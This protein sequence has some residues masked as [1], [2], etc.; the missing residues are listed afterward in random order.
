MLF[1]EHGKLHKY[2]GP[3]TVE[4]LREFARVS[5]LRS[6]C[7][8]VLLLTTFGR[9]QEGYREDEALP[10]PGPR[11]WQDDLWSYWE[12]SKADFAT[13]AKYKKNVLALT[14]VFG[15]FCGERR[16]CLAVH[17]ARFI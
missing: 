13:L 17:V 2:T 3:R 5:P 4:D 6:V 14:F 11:T 12:E 7:V 1:L 10:M 15:M 16:A 8:C 9:M